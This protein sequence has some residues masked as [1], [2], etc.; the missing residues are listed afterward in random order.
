MISGDVW[1]LWS[2]LFF[3]FL[4]HTVVYNWYFCKYSINIRI[5]LVKLRHSFHI[6]RCIILETFLKMGVSSN[7]KL[8]THIITTWF[9]KTLFLWLELRFY[10]AHYYSNTVVAGF[11]YSHVSI[12]LN[13]WF[14]NGSKDIQLCKLE[15]QVTIFKDWLLQ[16]KLFQM[17]CY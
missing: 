12:I 1:L 17:R 8:G 4:L 9:L 14:L 6:F 7:V 16:L 3:M 13:M 11:F 5:C 2:N 10:T 15:G